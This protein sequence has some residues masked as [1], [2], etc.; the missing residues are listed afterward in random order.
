WCVG[1]RVRSFVRLVLNSNGY[2]VLEA[3]DGKQA[4]AISQPHSVP[5]F[6]HLETA[7]EGVLSV[8]LY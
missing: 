7:N 4:L 2:R 3:I 6:G 8:Q 1:D 5:S